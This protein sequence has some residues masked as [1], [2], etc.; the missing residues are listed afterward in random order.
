VPWRVTRW[1]HRA[2]SG[3][4]TSSSGPGE[5]LLRSSW[6]PMDFTALFDDFE[7]IVQGGRQPSV[8]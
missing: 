1:S 8:L 2:W 4:Q 6:C 3:L 5:W 7:P